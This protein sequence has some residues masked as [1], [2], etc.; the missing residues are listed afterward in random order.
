ML[1]RLSTRRYE[2]ALE[3]VGAEVEGRSSSTSRASVSR[4][5]V[6]A[7]AERLAELRSRP[8]DYQRWLGRRIDG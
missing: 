4:R 6:A 8:L 2:G 1:T 5:F 7:A 3:P